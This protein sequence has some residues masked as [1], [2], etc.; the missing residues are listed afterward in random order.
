VPDAATTP[1]DGRKARRDRN[2]ELVL[3]AALELFSE[4]Q[5]EPNALDVAERS[6][7]SERSVFR[8]FEDRDALLRAAIARHLDRTL[9]LYEF[10]G[11]GEGTLDERIDWFVAHRLELY[12]TLASTA[13]AAIVRTATSDLIR[14]QME[15]ARRRLQGQLKAT[16]EPELRLMPAAQRRATVAAADAL[17]QFEGVEHLCEHLELSASQ[18]REALRHALTCLFRT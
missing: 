9:P 5:L 10:P 6:G 8:Y 13:R 16:F 3:D 11:L 14:G 2:R 4:G 7:V 17:F 15:E 1:V 12:R 18:A